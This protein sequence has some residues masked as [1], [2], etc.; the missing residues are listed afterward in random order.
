MRKTE[1][2]GLS[3]EVWERALRVSDAKPTSALDARAEAFWLALLS[4]Q[5][6]DVERIETGDRAVLLAK[7]CPPEIA[8]ERALSKRERLIVERIARGA[9][10]RSIGVVL[11]LSESAVSAA[12]GRAL[13]K[14]GLRNRAQ[15]VDL[16]LALNATPEEA[17]EANQSSESDSAAA[18]IGGDEPRGESARR[19]GASPIVSNDDTQLPSANDAPRASRFDETQSGEIPKLAAPKIT[20]AA[21]S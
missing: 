14:L 1:E 2:P 18:L 9:T 21:T 11:Q 12:L 5:W 8:R 7:R 4:G 20:E 17:S 6:S 10:S 13:G 16:W 19:D 3:K 15:L